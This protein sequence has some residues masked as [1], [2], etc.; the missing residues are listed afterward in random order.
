MPGCSRPVPDD[1][2]I[3]L[4]PQAEHHRRV[5][6]VHGEGGGNT[7]RIDRESSITLA[8]PPNEQAG[9]MA[10]TNH[11]NAVL[12]LCG[13]NRKGVRPLLAR[14][15]PGGLSKID[16]LEIGL[17]VCGTVIVGSKL[18]SDCSSPPRETNRK[19]IIICV[20]HVHNGIELI[21]SAAT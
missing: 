16:L 2:G 8:I 13:W 18:V 17:C 3:G 1:P 14:A 19:P 11:Y 20:V 9:R 10:R 21:T 5:V 6:V 4:W 15:F 12:K 7:R